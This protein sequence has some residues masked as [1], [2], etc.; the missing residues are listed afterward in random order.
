[1][2]SNLRQNNIKK[3]KVAVFWSKEQNENIALWTY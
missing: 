1:M 2:K 3:E